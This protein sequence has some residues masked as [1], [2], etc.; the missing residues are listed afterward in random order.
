MKKNLSSTISRY[1]KTHVVDALSFMAMGLFCSLI[2]GL[3]IKQIAL[4]PGLDFLSSI[5]ALPPASALPHTGSDL[6]LCK[7]MPD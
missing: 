1:F 7:T 6:P 2:L 4:I 3:I 5:A